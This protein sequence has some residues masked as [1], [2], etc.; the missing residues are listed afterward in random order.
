MLRPDKDVLDNHL[1]LLKRL[2]GSA[3]TTITVPRSWN[4]QDGLRGL[5]A[6]LKAGLPPVGP[7]RP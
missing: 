6:D 7:K 5:A 3:P 1:A 4:G 2:H